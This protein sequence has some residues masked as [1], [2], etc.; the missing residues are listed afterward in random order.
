[1]EATVRRRSL[2]IALLVAASYLIVGIAFA[3]FSDW[4]TTGEMRLTWRR[5]AWVV[6]GVGFAAHIVYEGFRL[7]NPPHVTAVHASIAAALG[8]GGLAMAANLHEWR[9]ASS[10]RP[11]IAIAL[12]AWPVI[13]GIPAFL[14]AVVGA[15]LLNR[16]R[17]R[18]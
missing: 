3:Q 8:A 18:C 12:L 6:C 11:S 10:Y 2:H 13:T 16:W 5:L 4:A 15:A 9:T 17:R 7:R 14:V 1:M